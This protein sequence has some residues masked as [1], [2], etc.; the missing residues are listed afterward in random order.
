MGL[1]TKVIIGLDPH[2][3]SNTIAVLGLDETVLL[4]Q[5]FDQS[6]AGLAA[7]LATAGEF[8]ERVWAVEGANGLGRTVAQHLVAAGEVVFDVPAKLA[9]R[10]RVYSTGHGT[11]SDSHDAI[12]IAR[13][14]LHSRQLRRVVSDDE[15]VALRLLTDR[16]DELVS[17][18][19]Q[20][21]CRLHRLL[22]ELIPGGAP[23]EL[24]ADRAYEL[25][26]DL[27]AAGDG[28]DDPASLMRLELAAEHIWDI[29]RLDLRIDQMT[30]R[31]TRKI[32]ASQTTVTRIFG[33]SF[34]GA[35]TILGE[36]G[37]IDRFP[38]RNHLASYAGAAPIEV[39]SGPVVRHRLSRSGNRKLNRV[40]HTA[41]LVQIRFDTPGRAY[42]RRKLA[43]GKSTREA[44]RCLKRRIIDA[45]WRQLQIDRQ[46]DQTQDEQWPRW[47]SS[48]KDWPSYRS[49]ETP[50][51][52]GRPKRRAAPRC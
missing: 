9:T 36:V 52:N 24:T 13:A 31:I 2:K 3:A 4:D 37:N 46:S 17:A 12:S 21:V 16:R 32:K 7:M 30:A 43:E 14:A 39:S 42:Y 1:V 22:R 49:P 19:T 29:R 26:S 25:I 35:A 23:R 5:R 8:A 10:V 45:V 38:T 44:L 41:A 34:L 28:V 20:T 51:R 47:P 33:I 11:K 48:R 40:I 6:E 50:R 27:A 18:R 15:N